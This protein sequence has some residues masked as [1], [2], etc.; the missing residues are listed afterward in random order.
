MKA[1]RAVIG[2]MALVAL[3]GPAAATEAEM[4]ANLA[5]ALDTC[6]YGA[7]DDTQRG[8]CVA[9]LDA[10]CRRQ[11]QVGDDPIGISLCL[12]AELSLWQRLMGVEYE[13]LAEELAH[14][15]N[16]LGQAGPEFRRRAETLRAAQDAW[17]VFRDAECES[18]VTQYGGDLARGD[19][20]L[21][22]R[23][24]VEMTAARATALNGRRSTREKPE[25]KP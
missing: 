15:D 23:C 21:R 9:Q 1:F 13:V 6:F 4:A 2:A 14:A 24:Q 22:T 25:L 5:P 3:A 12:K 7:T 11:E 20:I 18:R 8:D 17:A 16:T 19:S 10:L